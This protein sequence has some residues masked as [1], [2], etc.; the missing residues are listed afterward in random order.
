MCPL[1]LKL[2]LKAARCV[3]DHEDISNFTGSSDSAEESSILLNQMV[4]TGC[5]PCTPNMP[6]WRENESVDCQTCLIVAHCQGDH[7]GTSN[8]GVGSDG[9][10]NRRGSDSW[11]S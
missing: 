7:V 3:G 4:L 8:S 11:L 6:H 9:A 1:T 10:E 2:T 5:D